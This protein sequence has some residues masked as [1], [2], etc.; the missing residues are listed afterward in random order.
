LRTS[1]QIN[2]RKVDGWQM[3]DTT[4]I[5]EPIDL[6]SATLNWAE[7]SR[8]QFQLNS[9]RHH[10]MKGEPNMSDNTVMMNDSRTM[11]VEQFLENRRGA[12]NRS[13]DR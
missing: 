7:D 2:I 10:L 4:Q 3:L 6:E 12:Q 5:D 11:S 8:Q 9:G 1:G 13:G